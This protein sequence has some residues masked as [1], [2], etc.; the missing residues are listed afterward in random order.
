MKYTPQKWH[1]ISHRLKKGF[2]QRKNDKNQRE[3]D[4]TFDYSIIQLKKDNF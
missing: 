4:K 1:K 2:F 3:G